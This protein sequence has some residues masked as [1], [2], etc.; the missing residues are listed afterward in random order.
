MP[1]EIRKIN[2]TQFRKHAS[3]E[4]KF[5]YEELGH[6]WLH[7][8]CKPRCVVIPMRDELVLHR[9]IGLDP[10]E[11]MHRAMVDADRM[12]AAIEERKRWMSEPVLPWSG[13]YPSVGMD[14][15]TYRKWKASRR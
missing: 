11:V 4:L 7:N 10:I 1:T 6:L 5:V 3:H 15:E 12:V 8:H 9:A 2:F 14:D 13:G